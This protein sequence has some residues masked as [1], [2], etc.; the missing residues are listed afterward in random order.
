L[1]NLIHPSN[2]NNSSDF[3]KL[4]HEWRSL[5]YGTRIMRIDELLAWLGWLR[6]VV[7]GYVASATCTK[8]KLPKKPLAEGEE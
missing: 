1:S 5:C 3:R 2:E 4:Y 6:Q 7:R 8:A